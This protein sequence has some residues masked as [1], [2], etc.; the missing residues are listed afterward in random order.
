VAERAREMILYVIL[1]IIDAGI[2]R[3]NSFLGHKASFLQLIH[4]SLLQCQLGLT[5]QDF[6]GRGELLVGDWGWCAGPTSPGRQA[7][8]AD[9]SGSSTGHSG[10]A[11]RSENGMDTNGYGVKYGLFKIGTNARRIILINKPFNK[12]KNKKYIVVYHPRL[13]S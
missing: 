9:G 7:R 5:R 1:I 12:T 8:A 4:R 6:D 13:V 10:L 11:S 2:Y 3:P